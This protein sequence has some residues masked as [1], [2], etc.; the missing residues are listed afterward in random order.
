M[1]SFKTIQEEQTMKTLYTL[2]AVTVVAAAIFFSACDDTPTGPND[3]GGDT[4]LELTRVGN[5]F[6]VYLDAESYPPA[7]DRMKDSVV[8]TRNDNGIVTTHAQIRFDSLFVVALDSALGTSALPY[9]AKLAIVDTYVK[10]Y[11]A[12]LDTTDKQA[13]KIAFDLK[14]KV[15]SDGIQEFVTS[16]G[17]QSRPYTIVKYGAAVGDKYEF[18]NNEGVKITRTVTYK[19][20]TDDYGIGFW[21]IKIIKVEETKEDPLVEKVTYYTNHKFGLVGIVMRTKTGKE[22]K[23]GIFPPT[24]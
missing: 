14:M 3:L 18:T 4:N 24:L 13:M 19:S 16:K 15:T 7:F 6:S 17:D 2:I 1:A 23:L 22:L 9:A 5:E 12:T 20:T 21:M 10:K 8:I 11:G